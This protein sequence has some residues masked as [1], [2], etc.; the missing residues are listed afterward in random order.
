MLNIM[1]N[2]WFHKAFVLCEGTYMDVSCRSKG[3]FLYST[4]SSP[5]DCSN[6]FTLQPLEDLFTPPP[7]L[8]WEDSATLQFFKT[9]C[10]H[11]HLCLYPG[12]HL[13]RTK[14]PKLRSGGS[15]SCMSDSIIAILTAP[16]KVLATIVENMHSA[17]NN[18]K[19]L[20]TTIVRSYVIYI[21]RPHKLLCTNLHPPG[22]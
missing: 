8:L 10:S 1:H 15:F 2:N 19:Q 11:N 12:T 21:K 6:H 13:C 3:T 7:R 22:I 20:R 4:V 18:C 14:L 5:W 17:A 9:A 16:L